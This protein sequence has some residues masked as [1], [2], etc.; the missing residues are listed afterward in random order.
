MLLVRRA[1]FFFDGERLYENVDVVLDESGARLGTDKSDEV[2]SGENAI[3]MPS[4]MNAHAHIPMI[5]FRGMQEDMT[6]H[7]WLSSVWN[8]ERRWRRRFAFPASLLSLAENVRSGNTDVISMYWFFEETARAAEV[9]GLN[10]YTGPVFLDAF[11]PRP[12][13]KAA[14]IVFFRRWKRSENVVP[15]VFAHGLYTCGE[16]TMETVREI[17]ERF[18][19][20][21]Q[22]HVSETRREVLDVR[23]R[24]GN[25]PVYVLQDLGLLDG[26][27]YLVHAGWLTKN[28]LRLVSETGATLVHCPSSNMKLATH[29]FF[30]WR[31]AMRIG[32]RVK[33]GTDSQASNNTQDIFFE[34]RTAALLHK[35]NYWDASVASVPE[36]LRAARG[37][38]WMLVDISDLRFLPLSSKNVLANLI[39]NGSGALVRHVFLNG[40]TL[41]PFPSHVRRTL[42]RAKRELEKAFTH[43]YPPSSDDAH[44]GGHK[45]GP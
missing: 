32:V 9:I 29:G 15:T 11:L 4:F 44:T 18:S 17:K 37:S 30:P 6:F 12:I 36:L 40:R 16:E 2:V 21:F 25:Y 31:E 14:A 43:F 24:W 23:E 20:P 39:Y 8:A 42:D 13:V 10:L 28:E 33:L 1:R 7:D 22:I 5:V 45:E 19:A 41:Y 35:N 27:T 3:L 34:M 38:G 26:D